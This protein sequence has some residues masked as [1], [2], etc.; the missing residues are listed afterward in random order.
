MGGISVGVIT[1]GIIGG[2]LMNVGAYYTFKGEIF[3]SV[4]LYL[5]ADLMW[6]MLS[7]DAKD[8]IGAIF[9]FIGMT[10]GIAAFYKMGSGKMKKD[11]N[12]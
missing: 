5:V 9:I 10:L 12:W 11:L 6:I 3:K 8:Y 7:V 4:M 1:Y 2:L